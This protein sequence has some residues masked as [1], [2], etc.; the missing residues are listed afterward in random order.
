M[1]ASKLI[2]VFIHVLFY[3]FGTKYIVH[4]ALGTTH[5]TLIWPCALKGNVREG[6]KKPVDI[7][8]DLVLTIFRFGF[9]YNPETFMD[10]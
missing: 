1:N 9:V 3:I 8:L 2:R 6:K 4:R 7:D 10:L 5:N